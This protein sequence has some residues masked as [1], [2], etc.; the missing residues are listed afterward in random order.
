MN[1]FEGIVT[2]GSGNVVLF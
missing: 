2:M 1:M